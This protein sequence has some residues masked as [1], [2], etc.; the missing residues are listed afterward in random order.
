MQLLS[1]TGK[2]RNMYGLAEVPFAPFVPF[3]EEPV[4]QENVAVAEGLNA[5]ETGEQED[6]EGH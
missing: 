6:V 1:R 2:Q 5:E 4:Q 3:G